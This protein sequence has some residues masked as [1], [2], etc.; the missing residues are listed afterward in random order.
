MS[1]KDTNEELIDRLSRVLPG[2]GAKEVFTGL[3]VSRVSVCKETARGVYEPA[4]C[5]VA[6]GAKQA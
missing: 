2:D 5:F 4:F 1:M 6:Q 3:N